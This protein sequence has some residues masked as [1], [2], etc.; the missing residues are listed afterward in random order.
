MHAARKP[1]GMINKIE[2]MC[3]VCDNSMSLYLYMFILAVL[4]L[5]ALFFL[6]YRWPVFLFQIYCVIRYVASN[7]NVFEGAGKKFRICSSL[8]KLIKSNG[9]YIIRTN[10]KI[11]YHTETKIFLNFLAHSIH[12]FVWLCYLENI[13]GHIM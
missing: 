8:K 7:C 2:I 12:I 6:P 4:F 1:H 5:C 3:A 10:G 11:K 9:C 13:C